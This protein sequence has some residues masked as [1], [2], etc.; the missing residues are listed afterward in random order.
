MGH[1]PEEGY[2]RYLEVMFRNS[3][4]IGLY[5]GRLSAKSRFTSHPN[6]FATADVLNN[7]NFFVDSLP[8]FTHQYDEEDFILYLTSNQGSITK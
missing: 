1:V 6:Y 5:G 2:Q 4:N 7:V 8:Y 3:S